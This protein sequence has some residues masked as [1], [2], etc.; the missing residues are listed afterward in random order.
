MILLVGC[1]EYQ[2]SEQATFEKD[3]SQRVISVLI[4]MSG[5]FQQMMDTEGKAYAFLLGVIDRYFKQTIGSKDRLIVSIISGND[6]S[7]LWDGRPIDLK[8]D[9][10][11]AAAFHELLKRKADAKG[12]LVHG[13]I[14]QT[15]RYM[16]EDDDVRSRRTAIFV[17]SDM[18]DTSDIRL[19]SGTVVKVPNDSVE[20]ATA[21][22]TD[23]ADVGGV[24]GIFY[25]DQ[26]LCGEWKERLRDCGFK[27]NQFRVQSDIVGRPQFPT[28]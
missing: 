25:A 11:N 5:S 3:D 16:L 18:M 23:F 12:S 27:P 7:L 15:I 17:L 2:E 8:K 1:T 20:K 22:L 14:T 6:R 13:A 24:I 21:A 10:P 28:F 26:F 4:D 9:Y 19:V